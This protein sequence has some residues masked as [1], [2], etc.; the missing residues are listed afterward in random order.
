MLLV[1]TGFIP[2]GVVFCPHSPAG[3]IGSPAFKSY[4]CKHP[5]HGRTGLLVHKGNVEADKNGL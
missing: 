4:A 3:H 5:W 2:Q 1:K